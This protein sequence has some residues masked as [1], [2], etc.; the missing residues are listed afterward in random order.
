MPEENGGTDLPARLVPCVVYAAKSTEDHRGSIPDQLRECEAALERISGRRIE[1]HYTDEAV[2]AFT[3]SR[4][5]GLVDAMQH[6]EDLAQEHGAAEL[7]AQHSDRLARGD[8]RSARHAVEIALW[9]L[10]RDVKVHTVQDPDTFRDLL[11]A[12]VTGQRNH[13]DSRRKGAAMAAGRRRAA[14]R[15]DFIGYKPDG[16]KLTVDIDNDGHIKKRMVIDPDRQAA[17]ELIF[18]MALRGRRT[19]KI[20]RALNDAGWRTKAYGKG[21][22]AKTWSSERVDMILRNPRY[23]ALAVFEGEI[24][25]RGHWP[26]YITERQH[27]RIRARMLQRGPNKKPVGLESYLLS[28]L[29]RCGVCGEPLYCV[30]GNRHRDGTLTRRYVC[31]SHEKDRCV[32]R[33]AA[34]R[35]SADMLE[36]MIVASLR[37]LLLDGVDAEREGDDRAEPVA[38]FDVTRE[39]ELVREAALSG[40]EQ[41]FAAAVEQLLTRSGRYGFDTGDHS[42]PSRRRRRLAAVPRFEAWAAQELAG[43]TDASRAE[44]L[45][46]NRLLRTWF[47]TVAVTINNTSVEIAA[48]PRPPAG[49]PPPHRLAEVQIDRAHWA[50]VACQL[51]RP[52]LRRQEWDDSEII[53]A[54]QGW[55]EAN[56]RSPT[57]SEWVKCDINHPCARTIRIHFGTWRRALRRAGLKPYVPDTPPRNYAWSDQEVVNAIRKWTAE[58]GHQPKWHEWHSAQPGQPSRETVRKHFGGWRAGLAAAQRH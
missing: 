12:V 37:D 1:A 30:T 33:C 4:G 38:V 18:R 10:K 32:T 44:T 36:G 46:L 54:L 8:G 16:Y 39:R 50:H 58:H 17:I 34:P 5:P 56:G 13:E 41:S 9:A 35:I 53:G 40:D 27:K 20:A 45:S 28:R 24:L 42:I 51:D 11:Y 14:A 21:K 2:S 52:R 43:R 31:A 26:A 55:A 22:H 7:W 15:G 25:A 23:A 3:R 57:P 19:G 29:G 49:G 47:S 6:A 48:M